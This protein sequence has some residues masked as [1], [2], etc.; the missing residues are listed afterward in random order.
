MGWAQRLKRGSKIDNL[1]CAHGGDAVKVIVSIETPVVIKK[2]LDGPNIRSAEQRWDKAG[3]C[4]FA[5]YPSYNKR[6]GGP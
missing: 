3:A 6:C 5:S 2:L 4:A 1:T